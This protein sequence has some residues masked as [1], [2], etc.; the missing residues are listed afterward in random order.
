MNRRKPAVMGRKTITLL[1]V[2]LALVSVRFAEAQQQGKV[3][4]IG[5]LISS[6]RASEA[7]RMEG[8]RDGLRKL[9][10]VEGQNIIIE[11]R[12]ADGK[13]NRLP[14]L[15]AELVRL[16]VA[17]LARPGGNITGIPPNVLAR[18]IK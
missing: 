11:Y 17:S 8:F 12:Y 6:S 7:A 5:F 16:K 9:G 1:L 2:W 15:A 14:E 18:G 10:Y 3:P 13:L 4:R